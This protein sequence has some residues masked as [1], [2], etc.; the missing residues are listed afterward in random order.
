MGRPPIV[1]ESVLQKLE[2][3]FALDC[4]DEEACAYADIA[5]STLYNYQVAHP[6]F[7][8]RKRRLK[9]RPVLKARATVVRALD[10]APHAQWYLQRKRKTEFS[11]RQ[12][13]TGVDG[14][15]VQIQ[16]SETIAKKN[17]I[18]PSTG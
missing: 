11:E 2:Q 18:N 4:T 6:D 9:Q 7:L 14:A 16:L 10:N 13:V 8:E 5:E 17:D 1:D 12:E 3:A 15:P